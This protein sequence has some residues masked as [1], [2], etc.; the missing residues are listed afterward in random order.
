MIE[1]LTIGQA[2]DMKIKAEEEIRKII[3]DFYNKTS[4]EVSNVELFNSVTMH[5]VTYTAKIKTNPYEI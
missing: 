1:D 2:R 5:G 3:Q 4:I